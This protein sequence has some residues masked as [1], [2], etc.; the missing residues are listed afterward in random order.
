MPELSAPPPLDTL[1][2][3][4]ICLQLEMKGCGG[5]REDQSRE[6]EPFTRPGRP[7]HRAVRRQI[8]LKLIV[9]RLRT[10]QLFYFRANRSVFI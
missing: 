7:R 1:A 5:F 6:C 8:P 3:M 9:A 2:A 10:T 4:A